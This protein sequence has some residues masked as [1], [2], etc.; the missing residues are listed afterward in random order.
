MW[1]PLKKPVTLLDHL[2]RSKR[3][4]RLVVIIQLPRQIRYGKQAKD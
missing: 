1:G 4:L 3:L 2:E